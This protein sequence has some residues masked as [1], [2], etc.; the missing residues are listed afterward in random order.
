MRSTL[1]I[2]VVLILINCCTS[3]TNVGALFDGCK[4]NAIYCQKF[5]GKKLYFEERYNL[6]PAD[7]RVKTHLKSGASVATTLELEVYRETDSIV[8]V[9]KAVL[10][11]KYSVIRKDVLNSKGLDGLMAHESHHF[12]ITEIHARILQAKVDSL[13]TYNKSGI[14]ENRIN[15]LYNK[16]IR[17]IDKMQNQYDKETK[18]GTIKEEQLRWENK[19]QILL[20]EKPK[21]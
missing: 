9:A 2:I 3:I 12:M 19:I 13:L 17:Q 18:H 21:L 15:V 20:N 5:K 7:F 10:L 6:T 1:S 14:L 16:V 4:K 8:A 11:K